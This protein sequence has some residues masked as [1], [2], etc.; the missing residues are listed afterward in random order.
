MDLAK[1]LARSFTVDSQ[2]PFM[3]DVKS[4]VAFQYRSCSTSAILPHMKPRSPTYQWRLLTER[5][6]GPSIDSELEKVLEIL[7]TYWEAVYVATE[8]TRE[9][10]VGKRWAKD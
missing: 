3:H 4:F 6:I 8:E 5:S 9:K 1:G 2:D 10:V 7:D